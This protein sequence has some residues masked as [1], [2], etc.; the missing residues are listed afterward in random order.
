MPTTCD[1]PSSQAVMTTQTGKAIV[2]LLTMP[3]EARMVATTS[4]QF[5]QTKNSEAI[6]Q[7]RALTISRVTRATGSSKKHKTASAQET[8]GDSSA[9]AV[10]TTLSPLIQRQAKRSTCRMDWRFLNSS[11]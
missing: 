7:R 4:T 3:P 9:A 2:A 8:L 11:R 10:S 5:V 6:C 1:A